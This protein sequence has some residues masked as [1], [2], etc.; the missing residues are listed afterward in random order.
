MKFPKLL[1]FALA[2]PLTIGLPT[3]N[4]DRT[5]ISASSSAIAQIFPD[6]S[7]PTIQLYLYAD[8]LASAGFT[9]ESIALYEQ[10]LQQIQ[11]T[12]DRTEEASFLIKYCV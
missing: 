3:L 10:L 9:T 8:G 4:F 12:G 11:E 2:I 5:A 7:D 1:S 6:I